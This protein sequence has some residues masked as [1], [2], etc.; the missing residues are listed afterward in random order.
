MDPLMTNSGGRASEMTD[1]Y[2]I[3]ITILVALT[4]LAAAA[5]ILSRCRHLL[6]NPFTP[7]KW[8][9][10]GVPDASAGEWPTDVVCG[11]TEVVTGL[12][13]EPFKD[14][15]MPLPDALATLEKLSERFAV[16]DAARR[17]ASNDVEREARQPSPEC[18]ICMAAPRE[19]RFACGHAVCCRECLPQL[20]S[21][22]AEASGCPTCR[23]PL[24]GE[25]SA[26]VSSATSKGLEGGG[27]SPRVIAT[28]EQA[29]ASNRSPPE[30]PLA[31]V[32]ATSHAD[33]QAELPGGITPGPERSQA[34]NAVAL[35]AETPIPIPHACRGGGGGRG[36]RGGGRGAAGRGE[37]RGGVSFKQKVA[38]IKTELGLDAD[39]PSIA[40]IAEANEQ[41]GLV[42]EGSLPMQV[43]ALLAVLG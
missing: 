20:L 7:V 40:A 16:D 29:A 30:A 19:M 26:V 31:Q 18:I 33:R 39:L 1:G 17:A 12:A 3:G 23:Q 11:L 8:V 22:F 10:P 38:M 34:A 24:R 41:M 35:L 27:D 9:A 32:S 28:F 15:R 2:A 13:V 42:G 43:D 5:D 21:Q 36:G 14:D 6:R 37:G 4:K 25:A